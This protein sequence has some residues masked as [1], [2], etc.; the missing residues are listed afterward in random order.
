VTDPAADLGGIHD[1]PRAAALLEAVREFLQADVMAATDGRVQ[2]LTRVCVNVLATVERELQLGAAQAAAHAEGLA[3]LG[4]H[5]ERALA[6]AI[7]SG[8]L[9]ARL[10]EVTA[11]VR[12]TVRAKLEVANPGYLES[13]PP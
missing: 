13:P 2:F 5:D 3:R 10:D 9:D 12:D 6:D 8:A 4:L 7:R 11:F 1:I